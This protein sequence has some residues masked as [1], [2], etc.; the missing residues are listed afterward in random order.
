MAQSNYFV[1]E[2]TVMVTENLGR[3]YS[4]KQ[5]PNKAR[6]TFEI[7]DWVEKGDAIMGSKVPR[8]NLTNTKMIKNSVE[9]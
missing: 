4:N 3:S 7:G 1:I 8:K 6:L 2:Q 5:M 9:Y